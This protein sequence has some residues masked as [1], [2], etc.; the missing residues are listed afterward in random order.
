M[1]GYLPLM[2]STPA[3]HIAVFSDHRALAWVLA[4]NR[5]A[6]GRASRLTAQL[7]PGSPL[8]LHATTR[9]FRG[10]SHPSVTGI[11]G[12]ATVTTPLKQLAEPLTL[13]D[14]T[15]HHGCALRI[16]Q[17]VKPP[18]AVPLGKLVDRLHAFQ[19]MTGWRFKLMNSPVGLDDHDYNLLAERLAAVAQD[20]SAVIDTYTKR[21]TA[22]A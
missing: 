22:T 16:D 12:H 7:Q 13:G 14:L 8:L 10:S 2:E 9:C 19:G 15:L 3:A 17:L 4:N 18:D 11:V 5:M 1:P 6:F 21:A 20:P